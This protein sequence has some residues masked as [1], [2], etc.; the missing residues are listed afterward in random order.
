MAC[1]HTYIDELAESAP[2]GLRAGLHT[3]RGTRVHMHMRICHNKLLMNVSMVHFG[4]GLIICGHGFKI[5]RV[6]L[7]VTSLYIARASPIVKPFLRS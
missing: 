5:L 4:R 2:A 1:A 3:D 7:I 6:R